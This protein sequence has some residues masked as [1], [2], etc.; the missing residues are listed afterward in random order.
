MAVWPAEDGNA[1]RK[2]YNRALTKARERGSGAVTG[3]SPQKR[4]PVV[5]GTRD[6]DEGPPVDDADIPF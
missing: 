3:T 2:A 6:R 1:K 4:F 5:A